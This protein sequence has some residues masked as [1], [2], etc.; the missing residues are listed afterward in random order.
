MNKE[1]MFVARDENGKEVAFELLYTKNVDNVP[2]M[3]YTDGTTDE[4]GNKN[5]YISKYKR[6][7]NSFQI[8]PIENEDELNK[9]SEIFLSEYNEN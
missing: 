1:K 8:E 7:A 4:D 3:W 5:V 2:I 9:Y 6:E